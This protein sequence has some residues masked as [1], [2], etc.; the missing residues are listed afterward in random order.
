MQEEKRRPVFGAGLP[1][2]DG[3]PIDLDRA[4]RSVLFRETFLSLGLR[5]DLR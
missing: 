1:V 4:I 2:K 3:E 5:E